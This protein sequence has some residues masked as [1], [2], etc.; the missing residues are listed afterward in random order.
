M[1]TYKNTNTNTT[2]NTNVDVNMDDQFVSLK[3]KSN[4]SC[5]ILSKTISIPIDKFKEKMKTYNYF[6]DEY[7]MDNCINHSTK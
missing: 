2:E 7:E 5:N 4:N 6:E 1:S 3:S